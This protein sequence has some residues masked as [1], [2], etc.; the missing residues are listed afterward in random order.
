[1]SRALVV[2]GAGGHGREL[3]DVV[4]ACAAASP[5]SVELVGVVDDAASEVNLARLAERG[6]PFLGDVDAWLASAGSGVRYLLGVGSGEVRRALDGRFTAAGLEPAT[7]VH[8]AAV[9]GSEV[10]LA[11]G[12]V[13]LAGAV[14]ATNTR[15]GRHTHVHR[16]ANVGH[17]CVLGAFVTVNPSASVSGDCVVEDDVLVGVGASVL[18]GLTLRRGATVGGGACVVKDVPEK[19]VVKG[20]PAR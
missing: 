15:L 20:V 13:V 2:V 3:L 6:V 11:P 14:V 1:M 9:V 18:Q 7:A 4:E 19:T 16:S 5:G 17:D 12:V 8:P 10:L